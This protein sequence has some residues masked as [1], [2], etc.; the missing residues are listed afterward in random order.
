MIVLGWGVEE[1]K[2][3]ATIHPEIAENRVC[4]LVAKSTV[5]RK[6]YL[7]LSKSLLFNPNYNEI[8]EIVT[9]S[10]ANYFD[11]KDYRLHSV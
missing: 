6:M 8:T 11:I 3:T 5:G 7:Q 4:V 10:S 9:Y 2:Q 1:D